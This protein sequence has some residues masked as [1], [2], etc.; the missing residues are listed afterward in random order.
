[1][2]LETEKYFE[3]REHEIEQQVIYLYLKYG[4]VDAVLAHTKH[5][6]PYSTMSIYRLLDKYEVVKSASR[7]TR[8][9]EAL[10]FMS[11]LAEE[12]IPLETLYSKFPPSFQTSVQTMHRI[13]SHVKKGVT[14]RAATALVVSPEVDPQSILIAKDNSSSNLRFG[15]ISGSFTLPMTFSKKNEPPSQSILRVLQQEVFSQ[16]VLDRCF[17]YEIISD[18]LKPFWRVEILDI[19][20]SVYGLQ[21]SEQQLKGL[22]SFRLSDFRFVDKAGLKNFEGNLRPG[23][24][25]ISEIYE[26]AV[27]GEEYEYVSVSDLNLA[28][29]SSFA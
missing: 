20:L 25:D 28:L 19:K 4:S 10:A 27:L 18:N 22:S 24:L 8:I 29:A 17:P 16:S 1:M 11:Y 2:T 26:K 6:L 7:N 5:N 12:K 23:I 9:D 15:K 13:L 3:A 21:V 14:R